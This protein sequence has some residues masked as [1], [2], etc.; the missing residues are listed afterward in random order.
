MAVL[1]TATCQPYDMVTTHRDDDDLRVIDIVV[2]GHDSYFKTLG[3]ESDVDYN[4]PIRVRARR[5]TGEVLA[6]IT[7]PNFDS[8][9]AVLKNQA[10]RALAELDAIT[11][12]GFL[13]Q[14]VL[15][16]S[17]T[18]T[19]EKRDSILEF[20]EVIDK[21]LMYVNEHPHSERRQRDGNQR[22]FGQDINVPEACEEQ[23]YQSL[24]D[25]DPS[26]TGWKR[27]VLRSTCI[28]CAAQV[29]ACPG[30]IAAALLIPEPRFKIMGCRRCY[31]RLPWSHS[32]M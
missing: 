5:A 21:E 6:D 1:A 11:V 20:I 4:A 15:A 3:F 17:E 2:E 31:S 8:A 10:S 14:D 23:G 19:P 13:A 9:M 28:L 7:A 12:T 24:S 26:C 32:H 30:L 29:A 16:S 18:M 27:L 22:L 25:G